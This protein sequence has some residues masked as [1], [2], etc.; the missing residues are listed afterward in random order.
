[1]PDEPTRAADST[2]STAPAD[3]D[4]S[5]LQRRWLTEDWAAVVVGLVLILLV[6][7]GVIPT[8]LVP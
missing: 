8:G 3:T 4:V 1:M 5:T 6:F 2:D 7:A